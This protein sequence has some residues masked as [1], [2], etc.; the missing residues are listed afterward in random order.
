MLLTFWG[1]AFLSLF[2]TLLALSLLALPPQFLF[3]GHE[4]QPLGKELCD[5]ALVAFATFLFHRPGRGVWAATSVQM[6]TLNCE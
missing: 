4:K 5:L 6:F 1:G 2:H 3:L